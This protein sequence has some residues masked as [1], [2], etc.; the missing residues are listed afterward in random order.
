MYFVSI[1]LL[2]LHTT[3]QIYSQYTQTLF[4]SLELRVERAGHA[5]NFQGYN[6]AKFLWFGG[7]YGKDFP[8]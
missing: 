2:L 7:A 5:T 1:L 8:Q 4:I 3:T 6:R